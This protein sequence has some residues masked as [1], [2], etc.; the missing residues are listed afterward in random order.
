MM[1]WSIESMKDSE[2]LKGWIGAAVD[3]EVQNLW[4]VHIDDGKES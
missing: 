2:V 4:Y 3:L 1:Q